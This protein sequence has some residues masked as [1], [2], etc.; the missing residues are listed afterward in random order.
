MVKEQIL[1]QEFVRARAVRSKNGD[2]WNKLQLLLKQRE[3]VEQFWRDIKRLA[4]IL[5]SHFRYN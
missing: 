1:K 3:N 2:I 4:I 5:K